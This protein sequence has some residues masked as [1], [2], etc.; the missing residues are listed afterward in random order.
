V[1]RDD[2][3]RVML[4]GLEPVAPPRELEARTLAAAR[5]ALA[6]P[7]TLD[8]WERMWASRPLRLAWA[9]SVLAILGGHLLLS[10]AQWLAAAPPTAIAA[11][12]ELLAEVAT[13]ATLPSIDPATVSWE[14]DA[15][16]V[17][18]APGRS[19]TDPTQE[20]RR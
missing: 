19:L 7:P 15:D 4:S 3:L 20:I 1:T 11:Q 12:S 5:R 9:T 14:P 16:V 10:L 17:P 8:L 18:A 13:I 2:H 6:E